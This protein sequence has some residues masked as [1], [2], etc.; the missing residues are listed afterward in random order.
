MNRF[1]RPPP[2]R[3][4]LSARGRIAEQA[5]AEDVRRLN[6]TVEA[7]GEGQE[8]LRKQIQPLKDQLEGPL[9][10]CAASTGTGRQTATW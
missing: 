8:S 1:A 6:G 9:G 2:L 7:L 5:D 10:K 3:H 4:D